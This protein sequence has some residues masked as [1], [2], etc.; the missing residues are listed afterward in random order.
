[1]ISQALSKKGKN[2]KSQEVDELFSRPIKEIVFEEKPKEEPSKKTTKQ[3]DDAIEE[4][5]EKNLNDTMDVEDEED[6]KENEGLSAFQIKVQN[7]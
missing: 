3:K 6:E 2:A 1:M 5:I 7:F 4:E